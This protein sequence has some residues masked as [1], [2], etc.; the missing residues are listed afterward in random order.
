MIS[1]VTTA[2]VSTLT[3]ASLASSLALIG[4]L[5]LFALLLLKELATSSSTP[6]MQRLSR[7][8]DDGVFPLLFAFWMIAIMRVAEVLH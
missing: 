2:T 5:V 1:T 6:F 8:L 7:V 3:T 4:I